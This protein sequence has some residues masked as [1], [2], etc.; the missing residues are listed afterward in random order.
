MVAGG[1]D[2]SGDEPTTGTGAVAE[3]VEGQSPTRTTRDYA[4]DLLRRYG[5]GPT[6][7]RVF[8][9]GGAVGVSLVIAMVLAGG[10]SFRREI[11]YVE[12]ER[13][14]IPLATVHIQSSPNASAW[15][16]PAFLGFSSY[17]PPYDLLIVGT[18][19]DGEDARAFE[20]TDLV[21]EA[22]GT[23]ELSVPRVPVVVEDL[24]V[25]QA[26]TKRAARGF[27]YRARAVTSSTPTRLRVTGTLT[28]GGGA[29][30]AKPQH[31]SHV[32]EARRSRRLMLGRW[33]WAF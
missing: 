33:S 4:A 16:N 1:G 11:D 5:N 25:R 20:L 29:A 15:G 7:R 14:S 27:F 30:G 2:G 21:V 28:P 8:L 10:L 23:T 9:A 32:F 6:I 24:M 3:P 17:G 12:C 19:A 22:D 31:F 18:L 13:F 26:G